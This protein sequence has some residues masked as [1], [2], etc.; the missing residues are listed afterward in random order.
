MYFF[1]TSFSLYFS[2]FFFLMIRRP[3]RSTLFPYTTL[4]RSSRSTSPG[5]RTGRAATGIRCSPPTS[6]RRR[7]SSGWAAPR[8]NRCWS[9]RASSRR[10]AGLSGGPSGPPSSLVRCLRRLLGL[11]LAEH[12]ERDHERDDHDQR[13]RAHFPCLDRREGKHR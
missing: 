10:R 8:S 2:F 11:L 1:D 6:S 9:A 7:T 5:S 12:S 4:F 13:R 3:P